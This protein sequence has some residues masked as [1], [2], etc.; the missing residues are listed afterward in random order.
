MQAETE[1]NCYTTNEKQRTAFSGCNVLILFYWRNH[2]NVARQGTK[3]VVLRM[4]IY[5]YIYTHTHTHT[6]THIYIYNTY[7]LSLC[8][9]LKIT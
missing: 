8:H 6:H 3:G 4:Y 5:I 2:D 1:K 9:L 7:F